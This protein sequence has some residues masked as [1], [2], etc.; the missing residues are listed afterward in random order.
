MWGHAGESVYD[1]ARWD[2]CRREMGEME[3]DL[4]K[5]GY[6]LVEDG[7]RVK[8]KVGYSVYKIMPMEVGSDDYNQR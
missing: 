1:E 7:Y 4:H 3:E 2:E 5:H 8:G 6:E